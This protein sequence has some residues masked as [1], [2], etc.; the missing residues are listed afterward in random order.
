MKLA[1]ENIKDPG[2]A[3]ISA[4]SCG[5]FSFLQENLLISL[6]RAA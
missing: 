2:V 3:L 6:E 5:I 1:V 4:A